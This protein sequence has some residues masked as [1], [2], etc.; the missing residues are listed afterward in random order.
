MA[1]KDKDAVDLTM[2]SNNETKK[3]KD[4]KK[5]AE[6]V[7]DTLSE[8]DRELKE[9]LETCVGTV[10]NAENET[11]VTT[12]LRLKALDMIVTELRTA[13]ASMTSVPKPLKFL[14]PH[15]AVLK[16]LYETI[17]KDEANKDVQFIELRARLADVLAVLAM[18]LGKPEGEFL[19]RVSAASYLRLHTPYTYRIITHC[20]S[21]SKIVCLLF[22]HRTGKFEIQTRRRKGLFLAGGNGRQAERRGRQSRLVGSRICAQSGG[23]NR[24]RVRRPSACWR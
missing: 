16:G 11:A 20:E 15:F 8:E 6:A 14:R 12:P 1:P 24:S 18:T 23:R 5:D 17:S 3:S 10:V 4:G 7:E 9:R 13:T 2:S 22:I 21:L 19:F